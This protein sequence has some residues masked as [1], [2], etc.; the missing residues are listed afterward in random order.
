VKELKPTLLLMAGLPGSGKST[1]ANAVGRR[2]A[3]PVI[4]KDTIK[5]G[6]LE[7][8]ADEELASEASYELL[9]Q[10]ARDIVLG[11]E[12][13][14]VLDTP[15]SY[16]RVI[17]TCT[18]IAEEA[19]GVLCIVLCEASRKTRAERLA[20]RERMPSHVLEIDDEAEAAIQRRFQKLPKH[21]L[22]V[23]TEGPAEDLVDEVVSFVLHLENISDESDG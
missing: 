18:G 10:L 11:Q 1:L 6:L 19:G 8:G 7:L 17:E 12:L 13:P 14:V 2:L 21:T 23:S 4:D 9:H 16:E 5:S 3:W 15:S 22:R 20:N